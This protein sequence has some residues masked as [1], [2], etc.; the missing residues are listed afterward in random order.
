M[1][2]KTIYVVCKADGTPIL[3]APTCTAKAGALPRPLYWNKLEG[4]MSTL[5][6][7]R[8]YG[9]TQ[10]TTLTWEVN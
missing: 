5:A 7:R 10:I 4:A 9:A 6:S 3:T 8:W 2:T 1:S